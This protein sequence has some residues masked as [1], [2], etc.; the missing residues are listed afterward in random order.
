[1]RPEICLFFFPFDLS[2]RI[3]HRAETSSS[4]LSPG[5]G[6][7]G[8]EGRPP[9]GAG[10]RES[11][12][13]RGIRAE[14]RHG[15]EAGR[16]RTTQ[17]RGVTRKRGARWRSLLPPLLRSGGGVGRTNVTFSNVSNLKILKCVSRR[18][19]FPKTARQRAAHGS[20]SE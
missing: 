8:N 2:S 15:S 9:P 7:R 6:P 12:G 19:R 14:G 3:T 10:C 13:W 16:R 1:M 20:R 5:A 17:R 18:N 11:R 4:T